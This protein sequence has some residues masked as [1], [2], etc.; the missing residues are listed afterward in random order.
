MG[1]LAI[2]ECGLRLRRAGNGYVKRNECLS[3]SVII[4]IIII[5]ISFI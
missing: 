5:I 4:I 2:I 1:K 3:L